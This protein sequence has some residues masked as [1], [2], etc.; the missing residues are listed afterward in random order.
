MS[1]VRLRQD[2]QITIPLDI[3]EAAHVEEGDYLEARVT[4]SGEILPQ[5]VGTRPGEPSPE[6]ETEILEVVDQVREAYA[7]ER[8]R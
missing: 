4:A 1:L 8:R 6:Q 2:A 3:R 5:P 7:A